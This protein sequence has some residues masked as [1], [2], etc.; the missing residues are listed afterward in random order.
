MGSGRLLIL[1]EVYELGT[2]LPANGLD[3]INIVDT[4]DGTTDKQFEG[5][6]P[7]EVLHILLLG[8]TRV[9]V[10]A[11]YD[12]MAMWDTY[13]MY[14][15]NWGIKLPTPKFLAEGPGNTAFAVEADGVSFKAFSGADG[16]LVL[17]GKLK[18]KATGTPAFISGYLIVPVDGGLE[19]LNKNF[20]P[21]GSMKLDGAGMSSTITVIKEGFIVRTGSTLYKLAF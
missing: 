9:V 17:E 14:G 5:V 4:R 8:Q 12:H 10:A 2:V 21:S 1:G 11:E 13:I 18:S 15:V 20:E 6:K 3:Y 7:F 19:F 16:S